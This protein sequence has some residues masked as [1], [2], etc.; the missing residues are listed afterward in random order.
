L[1]YVLIQIFLMSHKLLFI[2]GFDTYHLE[3]GN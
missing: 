1:I 3:L 2:N